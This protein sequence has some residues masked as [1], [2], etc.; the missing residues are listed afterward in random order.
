ME[1]PYQIWKTETLVSGFKD[2]FNNIVS[3]ARRLPLHDAI[4]S[5]GYF[6]LNH[7]HE[8][9]NAE[10]VFGKYTYQELGR[11][12]FEDTIAQISAIDE[13]INQLQI[14]QS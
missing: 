3:D 9:G 13:M 11:M 10:F 8:D 6:I 1:E 7:P 12:F 4:E 2:D 5:L 14:A